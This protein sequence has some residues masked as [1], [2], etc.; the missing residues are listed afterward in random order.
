MIKESGFATGT[1][2]QNPE[3]ETINNKNIEK[4]LFI[5]TDLSLNCTLQ[6]AKISDFF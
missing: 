6:W 3:A 4:T 5:R 2:W 1:I